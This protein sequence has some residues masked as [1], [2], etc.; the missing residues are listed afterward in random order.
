MSSLE[1]EAA[2]AAVLSYIRKPGDDATAEGAI[3][4]A[5]GWLPIEARAWL[6]EHRES[7][8]E[9]AAEIAE[10][11]TATGGNLQQAAP[12]S[13]LRDERIVELIK[14]RAAFSQELADLLPPGKMV[15]EVLTEEQLLRLMHKHGLT[16]DDNDELVLV[17]DFGR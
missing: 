13:A 6:R 7:L 5:S 10:A 9:L 2:Q 4:A 3:I 15:K 12:L 1:D 14:R 11:A 8:L 17:D 16:L